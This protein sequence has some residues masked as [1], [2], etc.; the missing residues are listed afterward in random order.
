MTPWIPFNFFDF[1][2]FFNDAR[3]IAHP[4]PSPSS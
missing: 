4:P 3:Q 2:D 1:F